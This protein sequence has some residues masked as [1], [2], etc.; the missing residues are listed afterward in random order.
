MLD[1]STIAIARLASQFQNSTKLTA[2]MSAIVSPISVL[3]TDA[4]ALIENRWI[5]TSIGKQLDGCGEIVGEPRLGRNDDE[6][7]IAIKFRV[8]VNVSEGTP[9]ALIDGLKFITNPTDCQYLESYPATALLFTNGY[10]VDYKI[11]SVMQDLSPAGISTVPVAVSF[12]DKPF[13]FS[14]EPPPGEL[15]VNGGASYLTANNSDIQVSQGAVASGASTLGGI[16][17]AELEV[18]AGGVYLDIGGATLAVYNPNTLTT[19]GHYNLT[20]VFQ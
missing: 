10:F 1:Y 20:G 18:G 7:R 3:E 12:A 2:L 6:Y 11:Q 4:D 17:P 15:F 19:L 9:V 14:K 13:R 5:D 16:V 8:F